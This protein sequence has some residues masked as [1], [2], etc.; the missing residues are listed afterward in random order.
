MANPDPLTIVEAFDD[1]DS[2]KDMLTNIGMSNACTARLLDVE[3]F[4]TARDLA[5]SSSSDLKS[6]I[7]N[8]NKLFGA[9]N[10]G[11]RIYFHPIKAS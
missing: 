1:C 9:A 3:G 11:S 7:E 2:M 4:E 5:M 10:T 8:V 6:T